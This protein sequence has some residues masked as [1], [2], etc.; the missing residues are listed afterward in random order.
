[1]PIIKV[2]SWGNRGRSQEA[3]H[4][5]YIDRFGTLNDETGQRI[6]PAEA[7]ES[8][9]YDWKRRTTSARVIISLPREGTEEAMK[10]V[11]EE[12]ANRYPAYVYAFHAQNDKG[13]SQPHL[14]VDIQS[15]R[16]WKW[17]QCKQEWK[18]LKTKL[19]GAFSARGLGFKS[20]TGR[21]YRARTQAEIHMSQR[22][23]STWKNNMA[24][25]VKKA[26]NNAE[27]IA[28]G[29]ITAFGKAL[30][31]SGLQLARATE[32]TL[33]IRDA[34]GNKCRLGRLYPA[35]RT[36][37]DV[38]NLLKSQRPTSRQRPPESWAERMQKI[39]ALA[40]EINGHQR[41]ITAPGR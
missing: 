21:V 10:I 16:G 38:E 25:G 9:R 23:L 12:L 36:P 37:R 34:A 26:I 41:G 2:S 8:G 22:G 14:H 35:L 17:N 18:S 4:L 33:T 5:K 11:L 24:I 20:K 28:S 31:M 32:K 7:L 39:A 29:D 6:T 30:A 15:Y 1:M 13:E 3:A 19:D 27:A 40:A